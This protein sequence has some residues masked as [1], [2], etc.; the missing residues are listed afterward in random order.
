MNVLVVGFGS[1]A[2]RHISN[3]RRLEPLA[4]VT[5][6]RRKHHGPAKGEEDAPL[7]DRWVFRED[8]ALDPK[9]DAAFVTGPASDHVQVAL[10][11]AQHGVPVFIEK[12][13][14]SSLEGVD[15]LLCACAQKGVPLAVG[16]NFRFYKPL[17][18]VRKAIG[19]NRIGRLLAVWVDVGQYLP[20]WRPGVDYRQTVSA[21][22]ALGGGVLLELSHDIDYV[23]WLAGEVRSVSGRTARLADLDVDVEDTADISLQLENGVMA[24]L[25]LDMVQRIPCRMA[26]F[27]GSEGTL[28]WDGMAHRVQW[29]TAAHPAWS[30]LWPADPGFDWNEMYVEELRDFL[31]CVRE[32]G[33]P[34]VTGEDARRTLEVVLA[35]RRSAEEG[36]RVVL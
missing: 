23:R 28:V 12:P 24:G 30:D 32:G 1:I 15:E 4:H 17:R 34:V 2:R 8:E 6:W 26:R 10:L 21:H 5:V 3:L 35:A 29:A 27:V 36:R 14:S 31:R 25:R 19:E 9:P 13:L 33:Q 16:Y 11:L 18:A 20:D 7:I 22:R